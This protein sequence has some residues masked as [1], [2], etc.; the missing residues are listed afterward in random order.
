MRMKNRGGI[1]H[2]KGSISKNI[3]ENSLK[4]VEKCAILYKEFE[5]I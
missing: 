1:F 5:I 2:K 4:N 3:V